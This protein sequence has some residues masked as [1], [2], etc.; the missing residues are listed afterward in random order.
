MT[1]LQTVCL[2]VTGYLISRVV[3]RAGAHL[4][5]VDWL[6]RRSRGRTSRVVLGVML[7]AYLLSTVV[8]NALTVLALI[9]VLNRLR[10]WVAAEE[11]QRELATLLTMGLVYGA[12]LGSLGS[13]LGSP[14][15]LY[16]LVNLKIYAIAGRESIHFV[17]WLLFGFPMALGLV[18]LVWL[19]LGVTER[20]VMTSRLDQRPLPP[21]PRDPLLGPALRGALLWAVGWT[22]L[23]AAALIVDGA[24]TPH[25]HP[26]W[27]LHLGSARLPL[28][29]MDLIAIGL[30]ALTCLGLFVWRVS[31][32]EGRRRLLELK[33]LW[34]EVPIKGV[35]LGVGVLVLLVIIA[36]SGAIQGLAGLLS[37][38]LPGSA[39][40]LVT[41]LVLLLVTV[42]ATEVLSNLTVATVFF[43]MAA[44]AGPQ[45]GVD[46]LL[47]MLGIS[48]A[49]TCAFMTPV[50]T[51]VNALAFGGVQGVSLVKFIKTGLVVNL[52]TAVWL[53][54]WL[55]YVVPVVLALFGHRY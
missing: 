29:L 26:L 19:L 16:L 8:P 18:L 23:L 44:A 49:S 4:H 24:G 5:F 39:S 30:T 51:P 3:L 47:L 34:R 46:P 21:R 40:P 54:V 50:A 9:P 35:L 7:A 17:S 25:R 15:N 6:V 1:G 33:D 38:L 20:R 42:F 10:T 2:F 41:L 28:T 48:L 27:V 13:L 43:P 12:N 11:A 52:L 53:A 55:T 32:P 31:T 45:L 36:K 22:L 14:G 37:H